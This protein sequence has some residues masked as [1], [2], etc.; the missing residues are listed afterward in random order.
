MVYVTIG[1]VMKSQP[2]HCLTIISQF[3]EILHNICYDFFPTKKNSTEFVFFFNFSKQKAK[4]RKF[5]NS[6]FEIRE[7]I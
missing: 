4:I 3:H 6:E 7:T 2:L 5:V 1:T